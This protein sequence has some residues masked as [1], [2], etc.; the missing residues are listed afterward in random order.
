MLEHFGEKVYQS[1]IPRNVRVAE[2]PSHGMPILAYD[3]RSQGAAAYLALASEV[4]RRQ[5]LT[6]HT[7][8]DMEVV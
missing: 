6:T 2:A 1:V 7:S 4:V 8:I 3:N 5:A